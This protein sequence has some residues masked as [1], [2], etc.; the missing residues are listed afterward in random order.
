LAAICSV[1]LG[2]VFSKS[3]F[4][5]AAPATLAWL[6]MLF[7]LPVLLIVA[8]PRLRGR[9]AVEWR[10]VLAYG[11]AMGVMNFS[12]YQALARIPVGMAVTI[13]F[14]GPLTVAFLGIRK[15]RDVIWVLLA[16]TG[17]A[18]LSWSGVVWDWVGIGFACL[19]ATCWAGYILL[20]VPTGKYWDGV[21]GVAVGSIAGPLLF[22]VPGVL[23]A[24]AALLDW[25]V[26][27]AMFLVAVFSSVLPYGLEM[28][29]LRRMDS[30]PF[31]I[32]M[33]LEPAVAAGLALVMLGEVL[34]PLELAAMACVIVASIG[35][36]LTM[37]TP[38]G[39]A[40]EPG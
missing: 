26:L 3:L 1:Q 8:R 23:A 30:A 2:G 9:K 19:A 24:P 13:E 18:L 39:P 10:A 29:A 28:I 22:A 20:A 35:A 40:P 6:R 32:L 16:G 37:G 11:T 17:V 36:T 5:L 34:G 12:I 25:R 7:A 14:L 27:L 31:S 15:L 21:T 38:K 33:S 4:D